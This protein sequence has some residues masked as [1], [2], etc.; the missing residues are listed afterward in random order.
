MEAQ[1]S[2]ERSLDRA[3]VI[4]FRIGVLGLWFCRPEAL[5]R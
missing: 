2:Q 4:V 3:V 1:L 5:D